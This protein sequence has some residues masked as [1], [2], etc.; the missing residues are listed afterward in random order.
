MYVFVCACTMHMHAIACV[1]K[2]EDNLQNR[3]SPSIM[4]ILRIKFKFSGLLANIFIDP[5][6]WCENFN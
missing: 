5:S 3:F 2:P 6:Y 4:W 1:Q